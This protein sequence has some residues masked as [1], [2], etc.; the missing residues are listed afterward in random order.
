[1]KKV[2]R[3]GKRKKSLMALHAFQRNYG[4]EK[5]V[6]SVDISIEKGREEMIFLFSKAITFMFP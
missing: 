4:E 3:Y 1:M 2:L 6:K 5:V